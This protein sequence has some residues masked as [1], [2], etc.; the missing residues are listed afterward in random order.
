MAI[1]FMCCV[2][3]TGT[4]LLAYRHLYTTYCSSVSC[5]YQESRIVER[6]QVVVSLSTGYL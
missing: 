1:I 3:G 2:C 5:S 4:V 6:Y